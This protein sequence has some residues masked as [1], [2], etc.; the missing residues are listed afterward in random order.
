MKLNGLPPLLSLIRSGSPAA[1]E[2][3][4]R[5]VWY[6][7]M[8]LHNQAALV[9]DTAIVDIV[10]LLKSSSPDRQAQMLAAAALAE[11]SRGYI[12]QKYGAG[13]LRGPMDDA[14]DDDTDASALDGGVGGDAADGGTD[15]AA[16]AAAAPKRPVDPEVASP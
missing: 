4:A 12:E 8:Q 10:V 15:A 3:A 13:A 1:Q 9:A 11:I 16:A 6:L 14:P 2:L 7:S 5:A